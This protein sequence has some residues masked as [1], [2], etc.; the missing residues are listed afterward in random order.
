ML[1]I[2]FSLGGYRWV[3]ESAKRRT[4]L[5][6]TST[7]M[8]AA[9]DTC[10]L[11]LIKTWVPFLTGEQRRNRATLAKT[12]IPHSGFCGDLAFRKGHACCP[13][14]WGPL[15]QLVTVFGHRGSGSKYCFCIWICKLRAAYISQCHKCLEPWLTQW[16]RCTALGQGPSWGAGT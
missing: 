12:W 16:T 3:S 13:I 10:S 4:I 6:P 5:P 14:Q 11:R 2:Q 7:V 15:L 9:I 1:T 8:W